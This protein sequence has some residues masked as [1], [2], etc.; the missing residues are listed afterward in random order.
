MHELGVVIEIV[1]TVEK[2][3]NENNVTGRV[4]KI[5]LQIGELSSLIPRYIEAVYPA[6]VDNTFMQD[7]KL[8]IEIMPANARCKNCSKVFK[9]FDSKG[10]CPRCGNREIELLSGR[11]IFIKEIAVIQDKGRTRGQTPCP[12]CPVDNLLT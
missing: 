6:A 9:A 4:D 3:I 10:V 11:E 5:V 1:N 8:E 2:Y 7:T 12:A